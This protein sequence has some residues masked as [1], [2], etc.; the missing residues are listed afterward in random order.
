MTAAEALETL[1]VMQ[2]DIGLLGAMGARQRFAPHLRARIQRH[3]DALR[4]HLVAAM[5]A[6]PSQGEAPARDFGPVLEWTPSEDND[7]AIDADVGGAYPMTVEPEPEEGWVNW[8]VWPGGYE[9]D[10][11]IGTEPTV[12]RAQRAAE[13]Y[14]RTHA[15]GVIARLER[16]P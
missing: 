16:K 4:D 13:A 2:A 9:R 3:T 1:A 5:H 6:T 14:V 11:T 7:R 15:M 12:E 10:Y 8:Q